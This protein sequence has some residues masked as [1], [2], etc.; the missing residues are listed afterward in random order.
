MTRTATRPAKSLIKRAEETKP[1][2][3]LSTEW[4]CRSR[5]DSSGKRGAT[6]MK[7]LAAFA[8]AAS[9]TAGTGALFAQ[10]SNQPDQQQQKDESS[11]SASREAKNA[12]KQK[13]RVQRQTH[14]NDHGKKTDKKK[15][16]EQQSHSNPEKPQ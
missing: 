13:N 16:S 11:N 10:N 8:I 14:D 6:E 12:K 7:K 2:F 4:M 1:A 9:L 15:Q 3:W 5:R